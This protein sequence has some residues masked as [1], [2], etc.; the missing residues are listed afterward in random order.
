MTSSTSSAPSGI[1]SA[2]LVAAAETAGAR[3]L[4]ADLQVHTPADPAFTPGL[5]PAERNDAAARRRLARDYLQAA[6]DRGIELVAITEH[7][8]VSW[9]D[10]LRS[11]ARKLGIHLLPGFEVESDEGIH[12]LC[13]FDPHTK[14]VD[15]EDA[16][17]QLG[18]TTEVRASNATRLGHR[19]NR[20]FES[21]VE[22]VQNDLKGICIAAHVDSTKGLLKFGAGL[23]RAARWKTEGLLACQASR[24]PSELPDGTRSIVDNSQPDYWRERPLACALTSDA[25]SLDTV[26]T[27]ATWIKLDQIGV[28]GLRQAFLDPDS[29]LSYD[30]PA[31]R[32]QGPCLVAIAWEGGFLDGVAFPINPQLNALI[33][34][35]GTG[36]S[37]VIESVR[38]AFGLEA[39]T[40]ES[41]DAVNAL[42]AGALRSG[43]KVSVLVDTGPPGPRR[44]VVER[45]APHAPVVRDDTGLPR[46]ELDPKRLLCPEIYGQ[47]EIYGVAQDLQ[48]RLSLL[49]DYAGDSLRDVIERE[50]ELLRLVED[51]RT[52]IL[53]SRRRIEEAEAK[54]AELPDLETWR[55]RFREAGFD[56]LLRERRLMDREQRLLGA[57]DEVLARA[58]RDTDALYEA[59]PAPPSDPGE[60]ALP[61]AD[62][63]L[64]AVAIVSDLATRWDDAAA[65]LR[66]GV[67]N[68]TT[69]LEQ[70]R[71][72]W[73]ARRDLRAAAFDRALRDL[74]ARMPDVDPERYLDVERRLEQLTPLR[75]SV[76]GLRDRLDGALAERTRLLI[77]LDDARGRKHRVRAV[78]ATRLTDATAGAVRVSLDHRADREA[79]LERLT[80]AKT[81]ARGESLRRMVEDGDFGPAAFA[82][83]VRD[84]T[85]AGRFGLPDGQ[86]GLLERGLS[87]SELLRLDTTEL[88]DRVSI[89]LDLGPAG[90]PDFR[91]LE[92]LS[93]GQRSTAILLMVMHSGTEPLLVDQPED[94][95]DNRFIYDDVVMRMRSAKAARQL[96]VATHNANI[97]VLGDAE[98]ILVLDAEAGTGRLVARGAL[99]RGEVRGWAE[100]ILEGGEQAFSRRREKY[101]W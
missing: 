12:V 63:I 58:R 22:F 35:K 26:G 73:A 11:A 10:E 40:D 8:D 41:R 69:S 16:L 70:V 30:D 34:G 95:L 75:A 85:L 2:L 101:G 86:A 100:R 59:R 61:D 9:I 94:D 48:A 46:P 21:L 84:R 42:R 62:L 88:L 67:V 80:A 97:P 93:P 68:A 96:V 74:Q 20:N 83:H 91:P 37:T 56:E 47:K 15:L 44:Y 72:E 78:A 45:T 57:Y 52:V 25:R 65:S 49:D 71:S 64:H 24:R 29:R 6:Q 99:D 60:E 14:V 87:E 38:F 79:M 5:D 92:R 3:F 89:E 7:N 50:R 76:V 33:G 54:L 51:N 13:L 90:S 36:K 31:D 4:K 32:R 55:T 82:R 28:D 27:V 17:A 77:E 23:S 81:G 98:Q 66:A 19:V 18:I 1:A 43:T 53:D 39:R